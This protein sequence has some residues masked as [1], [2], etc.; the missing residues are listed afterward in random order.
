M[1]VELTM[2]LRPVAPVADEWSGFGREIADALGLHHWNLRYRATA[3]VFLFLGGDASRIIGADRHM[4]LFNRTPI[5]PV[6]SFWATVD[7]VFVHIPK[8]AGTS[9]RWAQSSKRIAYTDHITARNLFSVVPADKLR[10][11][12]RN[13]YDRA[14]SSYFFNKQGGFGLTPILTKAIEQDYPTFEDWVL[15]GGLEAS[16]NGRVGFQSSIADRQQIDW[17]SKRCEDGKWK[18]LLKAEHIGRFETLEKDINRLLGIKH[19]PKLNASRHDPWKVYYTNP[20]VRDRVYAIYK[21]DFVALGYSY[22]IG[23]RKPRAIEFRCG[24]R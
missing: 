15:K 21:P 3:E 14:V 18:W 6:V 23:P 10:T 24:K 16:K 12:V 5:F 22:E 2:V 11:I 1:S 19:P 20:A 7:I 8:T 9:I 4:D 13:P 17:V